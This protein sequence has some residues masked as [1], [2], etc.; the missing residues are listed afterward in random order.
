MDTVREHAKE[1]IA[2][3]E[4]PAVITMRLNILLK[5]RIIKAVFCEYEIIEHANNEEDLVTAKKRKLS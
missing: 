2:K 5:R 3:R 4:A 1:F